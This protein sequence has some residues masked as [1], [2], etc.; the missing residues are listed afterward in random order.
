MIPPRRPARSSSSHPPTPRKDPLAMTPPLSAA[1]TPPPSVAAR[2][3][4][5]TMPPS[6][7]PAA[8]PSASAPSTPAHPLASMPPSPADLSPPVFS[9]HHTTLRAVLGDR[10]FLRKLRGVVSAALPRQQVDDLVQQSCLSALEASRSPEDRGVCEAWMLGLVRHKIADH[11]DGAGKVIFEEMPRHLRAPAAPLEDRDR[12]R[13]VQKQV[14]QGLLD[15]QTLGWMTRLGAGESLASIA[16]TD[17]LKPDFLHKRLRRAQ[18]PLRARWSEEMA[19][20]DEPD[21]PGGDPSDE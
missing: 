18:G 19:R 5:T 16:R 4:D 8:P 12:L 20:P 7:R 11:H 6:S 1:S 3:T 21:E 17:G 13:W 10:A 2:S 14:A 15:E 9:R